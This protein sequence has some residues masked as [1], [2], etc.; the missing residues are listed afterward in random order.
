MATRLQFSAHYLFPD[1]SIEV[2][3]Q[4]REGETSEAF[5]KRSTGASEAL[6]AFV[7]RGTEK[8][9]FDWS[10]PSFIAGEPI[11]VYSEPLTEADM[12]QAR[13]VGREFQAQI[14][15]SPMS[16][17]EKDPFADDD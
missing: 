7:K 14:E 2:S 12:E 17:L 1:A 15:T 8:P 10:P 3:L 13:E 16:V 9:P 6:Q 5:A 4:G 11:V